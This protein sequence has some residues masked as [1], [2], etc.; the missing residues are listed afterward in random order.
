MRCWRR[1]SRAGSNFFDEPI[2]APGWPHDVAA[3][4]QLS[5]PYNSHAEAAQ[6]RGWPL[7]QLPLGHFAP[8]THPE[9]IAAAILALTGRIPQR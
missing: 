9:V 3:Y 5:A 2:P 8:V 4:L 1:P 6:Q 7:E